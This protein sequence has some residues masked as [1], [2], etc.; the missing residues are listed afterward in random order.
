MTPPRNRRTCWED[1]RKAAIILL[2]DVSAMLPEYTLGELLYTMLRQKAKDLGKDIVFIRNISDNDYF[3]MID[4]MMFQE[5]KNDAELVKERVKRNR[6]KPV[7]YSL[8]EP[9]FDKD[10]NPMPVTDPEYIK[11]RKK[12]IKYYDPEKYRIDHSVE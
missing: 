11:Q 10:G 6:R 7:D 1:K 12:R 4:E 9:V 5:K 3:T 2:L 8:P